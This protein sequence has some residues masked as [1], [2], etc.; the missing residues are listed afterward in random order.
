M[1]RMIAVRLQNMCA[2]RERRE[3]ANHVAVEGGKTAAYLIDE[4]AQQAQ[5]AREATIGPSDEKQEEMCC[6][7]VGKSHLETSAIVISRKF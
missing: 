2:V 3:S 5:R 4:N 1:R 6:R 7:A